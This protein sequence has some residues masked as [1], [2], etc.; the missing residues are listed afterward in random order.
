MIFCTIGNDTHEFARFSDYVLNYAREYPDKIF[1]FQ[2][3]H[4][5]V[6]TE[7]LNVR[8]YQFISRDD[9]GKY[10]KDCEA[11]FCHAGAGTLGTAKSL[12]K[13]PLVLPR[14][15][16]FNEHV[17]NHQLDIFSAYLEQGW[18]V[19]LEEYDSME[20]YTHVKT[21]PLRNQLIDSLKEKIEE[22]V[23]SRDL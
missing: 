2:H 12:G 22:Y 23:G 3:G 4:T 16:S 6:T 8:L 19:R 17:D 9:F 20:D 11:I 5:N 10:L 1:I 15:K 18:V 21:T 13:I 7:L 14:M